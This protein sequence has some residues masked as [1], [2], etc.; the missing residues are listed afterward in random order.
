MGARRINLEIATAA[1]L[2]ALFALGTASCGAA[3][4]LALHRPYLCSDTIL[5]GWTGLTDGIT[6]S[7]AAPGCFA[8]GGSAQ[9][10]KV[11]VVDLGALCTVNRITLLSSANGNTRHVSLSVSR[12]AR[13]FE[14]LREY[15]FP[16]AGAQTLAHSFTARQARY[17]KIALHDTWANGAEGP[18]CLFLREVQVFGDA[19]AGGS[20]S[21]GGAREELRLARLQPPVVST[22]AVTIFRR[23]GRSPTGSC[24]WPCW[25]TA[26]RRFRSRI[27]GRGRTP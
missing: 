19:P 23:Y 17:V 26:P 7:D 10:P 12:D 27:P 20:S 2:L 5:P 6:D 22:P 14:Q 21:S 11:I 4:N 25:G 9:F 3:E 24:A 8:T 15:Y 18:N 13:E 1:A 16:A